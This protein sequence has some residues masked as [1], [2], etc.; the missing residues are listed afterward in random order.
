MILWCK[1]PRQ[2]E[3]LSIPAVHFFLLLLLLLL[4]TFVY[5]IK[6]KFMRT[7]TQQRQTHTNFN[8]NWK[9]PLSLNWI[10]LLHYCGKIFSFFYFIK[11]IPKESK[12]AKSTLIF[13]SHTHTYTH[14][15]G[16]KAK[17]KEKYF[18]EMKSLVWIVSF[19]CVRKVNAIK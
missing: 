12:V 1:P 17:N 5:Q 15:S 8:R 18:V 2:I 3:Y 14:P 7:H 16:K 13:N 11:S 19:V 6:V 9:M 10:K 4:C